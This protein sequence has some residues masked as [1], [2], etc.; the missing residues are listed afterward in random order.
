MALPAGSH[1]YHHQTVR[2]LRPLAV[3]LGVSSHCTS[4]GGEEESGAAPTGGG[5][6]YL[7]SYSQQQTTISELMPTAVS[8]LTSLRWFTAVVEQDAHILM[9]EQVR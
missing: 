1:K 3:G 6:S 9:W 4:A 5:K 8:S 2:R 7:H